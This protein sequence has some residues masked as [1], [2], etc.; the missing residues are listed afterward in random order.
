MNMQNI[1][2]R[3]ALAAMMFSAVAVPVVTNAD[4]S[5]KTEK[6]ETQAA[7]MQPAF[8][9]PAGGNSNMK[10]I[11]IAEM[12]DPVEL[13]K[14]YA[15]ETVKDWQKTL[16]QFYKAFD[17]E[18]ADASV[19]SVPTASVEAVPAEKL[20]S[21]Q[22]KTK[23]IPGVKISQYAVAA[24]AATLTEAKEETGGVATSL[25]TEAKEISSA[26]TKAWANLNKA[27]ESKDADAIKKALAE[28][29]KQYKQ[30]IADQEAAAK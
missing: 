5:Q 21:S 18:I 24:S 8:T 7:T 17:S 2:K 29:L 16:G 28:L 12:T 22:E 19:Q 11:V 9:L 27:N 10:E 6:A 26:F 1:L 15:P 4:S 23:D 3:T 13:A 20:T 25:S 30:V 14:K